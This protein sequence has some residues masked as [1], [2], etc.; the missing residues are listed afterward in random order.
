M[1]VLPSDLVFTR[2][3]KV[4]IV[5][6]ITS[7]RLRTHKELSKLNEDSKFNEFSK[8]NELLKLNELSKHNEHSK[9]NELWC[10]FLNDHEIL[11]SAI[12]K[13]GPTLTWFIRPI[14]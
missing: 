14:F 3:L 13:L 11:I 7:E 9:L 8:L 4:S 12:R 10:L 1:L 6:P 5:R 2:S